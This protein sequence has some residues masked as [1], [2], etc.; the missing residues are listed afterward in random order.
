[1]KV[2]RHR[3]KA[4]LMRGGQRVTRHH[5]IPH[6]RRGDFIH[7]SIYHEHPRNILRLKASRHKAFHAIFKNKTLE[8]VIALLIRVHRAKKRCLKPCPFCGLTR[9]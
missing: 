8:E 3:S 5:L 9:E 2:K 4:D 6:S 1:M 7:L